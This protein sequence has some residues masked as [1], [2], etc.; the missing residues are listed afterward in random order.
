MVAA[1]AVIVNTMVTLTTTKDKRGRLALVIATVIKTICVIVLTII[2]MYVVTCSDQLLFAECSHTM[3][4][5]V[6]HRLLQLYTTTKAITY[7]QLDIEMLC[8]R[9]SLLWCILMM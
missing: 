5:E 1:Q 7:Y 8:L 6:D 3:C 4:L 2:W 9:I